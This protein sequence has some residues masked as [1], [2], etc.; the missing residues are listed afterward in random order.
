METYGPVFQFNDYC[1]FFMSDPSLQRMVRVQI[2]KH[3]L[4][5]RFVSVSMYKNFVR[6]C[7]W[8]MAEKTFLIETAA[9]SF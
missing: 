8:S 9:G 1:F 3:D 6:S 7:P 4:V 2:Y 5:N